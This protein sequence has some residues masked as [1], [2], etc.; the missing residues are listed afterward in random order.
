MKGL[1]YK[2][3]LDLYLQI[4]SNVVRISANRDLWHLN[5]NLVGKLNWCFF[6]ICWQFIC[7]EIISVYVGLP[8]IQFHVFCSIQL[9]CNQAQ[10][11]SENK[12]RIRHCCC[13]LCVSAEL[14]LLDWKY[15]VQ[16]CQFI[17]HALSCRLSNAAANVGKKSPQQP[18]IL[19]TQSQNQ[20]LPLPAVLRAMMMLNTV[21]A[22]TWKT[23][24]HWFCQRRPLCSWNWVAN[25]QQKCCGGQV[26]A[27][28]VEQTTGCYTAAGNMLLGHMLWHNL[29][30]TDIPSLY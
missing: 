15:C 23:L 19:K 6:L 5:P 14:L 12:S 18:V 17:L 10:L 11:W 30:T 26:L 8:T 20:S 22:V 28:E 7:E 25:T 4:I 27:S 24:T 16:N 29:I 9:I 1:F 21:G 2:R 3:W 13:H